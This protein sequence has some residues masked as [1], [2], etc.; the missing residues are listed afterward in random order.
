VYKRP[1]FETLKKRLLEKRRFIQVLSGPRQTGKTTLARQLIGEL[2]IPCHYVTADEP[3]LKGPAWIEQQWETARIQAGRKRAL[4]VLDEIHK[5]PSWSE[6]VKRLW[7]EDSGRGSS[8]HVILLG[9]APLAIRSGLTESLAGRFEIVPV[10]HW[11]FAEMRDAFGWNVDKFIYYGGYPGS[12]ELIQDE[13]RW[14]R[15][16]ID[17]LVEMT[18]SQDILMMKRVDKPALLRRLFDLG[19]AYSGQVLSYQKMLG[20]LR[21]A[22]NTTTLA[23]YLQLLDMAGLITGLQKYSAEK[24]RQRASSP[25]LVVLNTAFMTTALN[26]DFDSVRK[27]PSLWGRL[28]ESAVGA[29]IINYART[30][31]KEVFYWA[32][33]NREVDFVVRGKEGIT[34]IE[35][36]SGLKKVALPGIEEFAGFYPLSRKLL[37]GAQGVP[38]ERFLSETESVISR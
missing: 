21:D 9:S 20:Q 2:D 6:T 8:L 27:D 13:G 35:V 11:S 23:H 31:N 16:I 24:V 1:V 5:I 33:N 14:S 37:I 18:V 30:H 19:C 17:S 7:D 29:T 4:L 26:R 38:V 3:A 34:A 25:K 15:Y 22:G 32:G 10:T 28:V 12:A 36:K